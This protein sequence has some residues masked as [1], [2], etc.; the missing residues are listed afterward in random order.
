MFQFIFNL[1]IA[2][3]FE[4]KYDKLDGNIFKGQLIPKHI[5]DSYF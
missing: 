3:T 4:R 1:S 5:C 2:P